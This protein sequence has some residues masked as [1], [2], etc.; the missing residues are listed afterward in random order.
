VRKGRWKP[1]D[2]LPGAE[3]EVERDC[4]ASHVW[5]AGE[6]NTGASRSPHRLAPEAETGARPSLAERIPSTGT[7]PAGV[8]HPRHRAVVVGLGLRF[9]LSAPPFGLRRAPLRPRPTTG[10][11]HDPREN[12]NK[13]QKP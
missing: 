1:G 12:Q 13:K 8:A 9:A 11:N 4:R 7:R 5:E 3:V 10:C 6:G 2:S